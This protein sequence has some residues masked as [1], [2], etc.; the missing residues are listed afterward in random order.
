MPIFEFVQEMMFVNTCVKFRD[1]RLRNEVCRAVAPLGHVRTNVQ[2]DPYIPWEGIMISGG[3]CTWVKAV[4]SIKCL[5]GKSWVNP[6]QRKVMAK[7]PFWW[8]QQPDAKVSSTQQTSLYA[9]H[10]IGSLKRM[11]PLVMVVS[12]SIFCN[13]T[14]IKI[15]KNQ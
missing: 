1:N 10:F 6:L 13:L 14:L 15:I 8:S 5:V 4:L 7:K 2:A 9:R 11:R 12:F 3:S